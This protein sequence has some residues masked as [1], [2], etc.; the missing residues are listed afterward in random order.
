MV[1]DTLRFLEAKGLVRRVVS[2]NGLAERDFT[3]DLHKSR[4]KLASSTLRYLSK[5]CR[6]WHT[7]LISFLNCLLNRIIVTESLPL[8]VDRVDTA[9]GEESFS[10]EP[11][12]VNL[13]L[14]FLA[15][16][17]I[18]HMEY[19]DELSNSKSSSLAIIFSHRVIFVRVY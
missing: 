16:K 7:E 6:V 3:L 19:F 15:R 1:R 12:P 5:S 8:S 17:L 4:L 10:D 18:G 14:V 11:L 2:G 9:T 13:I